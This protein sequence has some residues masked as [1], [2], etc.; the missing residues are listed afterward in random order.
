M[1]SFLILRQGEAAGRRYDLDTTYLTIGS[2]ADNE[3]VLDDALVS[4]YH[5]AVMRLGS[6]L[7]IVDLGSANPVK[8]NDQP[9]HAHAAQ[10]LRD[11]DVISI[12]A[13]E[14]SFQSG[15]DESSGLVQQLPPLPETQQPVEALEELPEMQ[16]PVEA[17]EAPPETRQPAEAPEAPAQTIRNRIA[18]W[19]KAQ[20]PVEAV[21]ETP[22]AAPAP[23]AQD[24][25][26]QQQGWEV[27]AVAS[28]EV[29]NGDRPPTLHLCP[30]LGAHFDRETRATFPSL[31]HRCWRTGKAAPVAEAYQQEVCLTGNCVHCPRYIDAAAAIPRPQHR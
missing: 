4:R 15:R 18:S 2:A 31:M 1:K 30:Y 14:F 28:Q 27:M 19:I 13:T 23:P 24:P 17:L 22:E 26:H 20:Q 9:L 10:Q 25:D 12:G 6:A 29:G 16:L 5:A 21:P 7:L 3:V 11:A 8:I